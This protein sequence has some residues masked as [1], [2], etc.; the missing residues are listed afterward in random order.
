M[1]LGNY[2]GG[3]FLI[4]GM[5]SEQK[6]A[7]LRL[8]IYRLEECGII[9]ANVTF[10]G[11]ATNFTMARILGCIVEMPHLKVEFG[12]TNIN[13]F[14]DP[15]HMCKLIRNTFGEKRKFCDTNNQIIDFSY[16]ELL[17]NLQ[18]KEGLHLGNKL[19]KK[20]IVFSNKK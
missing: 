11:S 10:D 18:E 6:A 4:N 12:D 17:N 3:Y 1:I 9:I 2:R 7:L 15:S 19:R 20:H 13:I 8:C 5:G 16:L 14:P